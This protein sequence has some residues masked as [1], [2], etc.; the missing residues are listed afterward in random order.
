MTLPY[1]TLR[2]NTPHNSTLRDSEYDFLTLHYQTA[3]YP[4]G[5]HKTVNMIPYLTLQNTAI[6]HNTKRHNKYDI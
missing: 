2:Y 6:Q 3:H 1:I 4:A 5:L